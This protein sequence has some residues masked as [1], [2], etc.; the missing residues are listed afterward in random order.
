MPPNEDVI[1]MKWVFNT[2]YNADWSVLKRKA[3]LVA[4]GIESEEMFSTI[5]R[6]AETVRLF[7]ALSGH[8]HW[9]IYQLDVKTGV[10]SGDMEEVVY[11]EQAEGFV[12]EGKADHVNKLNKAVYGLKQAPR[13]WYAVL[14]SFL[15]RNGFQRSDTEPTLFIKKGGNDSV[16]L[17]SVYVD[18]VIYM[19]SSASV[20]KKFKTSMMK[21]FGMEDLGLLNYFLGLEI[22]QGDDGVFVSQIKHAY[23]LVKRFSM[24]NKA[25]T[26]PMDENEKLQEE[27]GTDKADAPKFA[28]L[29]GGLN[30]LTLTRP[31]IAFSVGVVSRFMHNPTR[32]HYGAAKRILRYIAGTQDF[33]IW[34]S[35]AADFKLIGFAGSD[36]GRSSSGY[37][38]NLGSG[39]VSWSSMK[40]EAGEYMGAAASVC[41]ATALRRLL[42][43]MKQ[44]QKE[45]TEIF[46]DDSLAISTAENAGMRGRAKHIDIQFHFVRGL[47][48]DGLIALKSCN[49][50][51]QMADIFTK[52][53]PDEKH[54]RV[55]G[56]LGVCRYESRERFA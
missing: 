50:H 54:A 45:A 25:A 9:P 4:T 47:V 15:R 1:G 37:V 16:L 5:A 6:R 10:L 36:D 14:D 42:G 51:E 39:A 55:R 18:D 44:E 29:V 52:P 48:A 13:G 2:K 30:G 8:L 43:D 22:K 32:Q 56:Q 19:G 21:M 17:V 31:D 46:C 49:T 20:V 11:T 24:T 38:F 35:N 53:L 23:G 41:Q 34:Y 33:G 7:L 3:R 27:D 26:T 12:A 40:T 28:I